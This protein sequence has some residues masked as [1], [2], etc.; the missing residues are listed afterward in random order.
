MIILTV[1]ST[2]HAQLSNQH[3]FGD[4]IFDII[5]YTPTNTKI[6]IQDL[7]NGKVEYLESYIH[8]NGNVEHIAYSDTFLKEI[9]VEGNNVTITENGRMVECINMSTYNI[10]NDDFIREKQVINGIFPDLIQ[11]NAWGSWGNWSCHN[12]SSAISST[13]ISTIIAIVASIMAL[14]TSAAIV[15]SI[16]EAIRSVSVSTV[17]YK[18]CSRYRYDYPNKLY[19]TE[20]KITIYQYSNYTGVLGENTDRW[21]GALEN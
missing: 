21:T 16:A 6:I 17:Y 7:R 13:N 19:E 10:N 2:S 5:V 3:K 12:S 14:P 8:E 15:L 11:P 18:S 9:S 1:S 4:Y 20:R